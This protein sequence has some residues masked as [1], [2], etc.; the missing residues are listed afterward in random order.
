MLTAAAAAQ[1]AEP[2]TI[3]TAVSAA[4]ENFQPLWSPPKGQLQ[5]WV[6]GIDPAGADLSQLRGPLCDDLS[7]T[8]AAHLYHLVRRAG[9]RPVLTRADGTT[10][11]HTRR[12]GTV[13]RARCDLCVSIRYVETGAEVS[14]RVGPADPRPNDVLLAEALGTALGVEPAE[15]DQRNA[16]DTRFIQILR[17]TDGARDIAVCDVLFA[18]SPESSTMGSALRMTC[19]E[20]ARGL[21]EGIS[22][23]CAETVARPGSPAKP[24][25]TADTLNS[26]SSGRLMRLVRSIWPEGPLPDE[27]V[28]WFCRK[29]ADESITNP[30]LVYFEVEAHPEQDLVVLRGRTNAPL[31]AVGLEKALRAIGIEQV[32]NQTR[33]LPDREHLGEHLFGVCRV[34]MALTYD[35]P[36]GSGRPQTELLFGEPLF[37][38]DLEGESYLLHAGD[39]YWG[40]V[41]RDAVQPMTSEQ[42][43]AYVRRPRGAVVRDIDKDRVRIPRGANVHLQRATED[44]RV[45]L[46][47]DGSTL[48][49][50]AAAVTL[51]DSEDAEAA[52]PV[53]GGLGQL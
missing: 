36:D 48:S 41:H 10:V 45:V 26:R 18:R 49:V 24:A 42:F 22:R 46:L 44:E 14:V 9:G 17:Q 51:R 52:A 3:E 31:L 1:P 5:G 47:P 12:A 25:P 19:F 20:H 30:S 8:T 7:L 40:W 11:A 6:V 23:F 16:A 4:A 53:R 27:R 38:L 29:Y 13:A 2:P 32:S 43:D 35:Q 37:L 34:P 33:M 15:R 28:E 21:Y 50:P 39:G